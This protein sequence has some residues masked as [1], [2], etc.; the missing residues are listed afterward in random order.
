MGYRL[1]MVIKRKVNK[2]SQDDPLTAAERQRV[3]SLLATVSSQTLL[4]AL[5]RMCP[6]TADAKVI[7]AELIDRLP[8][9]SPV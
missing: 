9:E 8:P 3:H 7:I 2:P 1:R 6:S 5:V 4:Q